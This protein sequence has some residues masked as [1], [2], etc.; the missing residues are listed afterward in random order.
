[1]SRVQLA[2]NVEDLDASI[3]FY[4]KLFQTPPAKVR[5]DYAN[6]AIADPPLKLVLFANAGEPGSLNHIGVEV[7][8]TDEV[9]A[10]IARTAGTRVRPARSGERVVLLRGPGQDLGQGTRERL[11]VLHRAR[12]CAR[13][14]VRVRRCML[15]GRRLNVRQRTGVARPSETERQAGRSALGGFGSGEGPGA[16]E[17][18]GSW[19][20][21][22]HGV[23]P[24][25]HDRQAVRAVV[26]AA[27]EV[28]RDRTVVVG[29]GGDVVDAVGVAVVG[30]EVAVGVVDRDRPEPVDGY[31][32]DGDLVLAGR[33]AGIDVD[34]ERFLFGQAAPTR[35]RPEQVLDRV[36]RRPCG[37]RRG[38]TR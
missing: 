6:F 1:M 25:V 11:G 8:T 22:A 28:H 35:G 14:V 3:A 5:P 36:D 34:V 26:A 20:V 31:V 17:D 7:E 23:V 32:A 37:R 21:Q 19:P 9:A 2:L 30:L 10:V 27:T 12:R 13:H 24:A 38:R 33:K 16:V 15:P 29:C 4:S 18:L